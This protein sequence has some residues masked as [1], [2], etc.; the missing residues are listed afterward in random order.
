MAVERFTLALVVCQIVGGIK[1][2]SFGYTNIHTLESITQKQ[3][4]FS[5]VTGFYKP[6]A[7]KSMEVINL[8]SHCGKVS[9]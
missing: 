7:G 4:S 5:W 8:A 9:R 6:K 2:E 3:V 1:G